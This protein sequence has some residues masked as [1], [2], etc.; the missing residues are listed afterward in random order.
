MQ[1]DIKQR[2]VYEILIILSI[3][4]LLCLVMRLWPILLLFILCIPLAML[5]MLFILKRKETSASVAASVPPLFLPEPLRPDTEQD[6]LHAAFGI[7]QRRITEHVTSNHPYARWVWENP[8]AMERF[9][10]GLPLSILLNRAG[11]FKRAAVQTYNLQFCALVFEAD[12]KENPDVPPNKESDELS[13][14][15]SDKLAGDTYASDA[16]R[17]RNEYEETVDYGLIAFEWVNA[18]L[19]GLNNDCNDAIADGKAAMLIYAH[20]LPH[21][22]SWPQICE[23]LT[24]NGFSKAD[25]HENGICVTL[26]Q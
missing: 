7:L 16:T 4:A 10:S 26:P 17:Y 22:G 15:L 9:A 8:N 20:N 13:D 11:G 21:P 5:G 23:E 3:L 14:G 19:L 24:R 2:I 12:S 1:K 25:P 6:V 18:H